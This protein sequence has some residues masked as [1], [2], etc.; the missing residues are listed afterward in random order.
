MSSPSAANTALTAFQTHFLTQAGGFIHP[1]LELIYTSHAGVTLRVK[2]TQVGVF[3]KGE[4]AISCPH[5]A[6]LSALNAGESVPG[7]ISN[8]DHQK[9][10]G[11]SA[12]ELPAELRRHARP[13][14]VAA[15]WIAVQYLRRDESFWASYFDI[16]PGLPGLNAGTRRGLGELDTP[17]WWNEEERGWVRNT[18]LAKGIADLLEVWEQEW[19]RWQSVVRGWGEE[20]GFEVT[21]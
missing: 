5:V 7:D 12:L 1:C 4:T 21:W 8:N 6:S 3:P 13:Q 19:K 11:K 14:F 18:N 20:N 9:N 2:E 10:E 17:L 15:V 16:L